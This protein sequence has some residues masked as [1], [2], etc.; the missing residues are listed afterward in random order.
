[1]TIPII[2]GIIFTRL[3]SMATGWAEHTRELGVI[4]LYHRERESIDR[5]VSTLCYEYKYSRMM[6]HCVLTLIPVSTI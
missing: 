5:H 2:E 3:V 4:A 6:Y 1:M